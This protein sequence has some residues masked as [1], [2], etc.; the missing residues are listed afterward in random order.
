MGAPP[1]E[2]LDLQEC[3]LSTGRLR[4]SS[5]SGLPLKCLTIFDCSAVGLEL[6]A[7]KAGNLENSRDF[8]SAHELSGEC[9]FSERSLH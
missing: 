8:Q 9:G 2:E 6:Q 7:P 5:S 3:E 1:L 4:I